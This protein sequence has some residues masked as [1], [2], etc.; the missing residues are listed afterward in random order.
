MA[1]CRRLRL[2]LTFA[3]EDD[4]EMELLRRCEEDVERQMWRGERLGE[5]GSHRTA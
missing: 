4:F 3:Q 2:I 1:T 5:I